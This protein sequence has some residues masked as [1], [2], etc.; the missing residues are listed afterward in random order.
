MRIDFVGAAAGT[1]AR[2]W[3]LD[4]PIR[5]DYLVYGSPQI[6]QPEIDEVVATLRSGWLGT[7]PRVAR[8]ERA[9]RDYVGA[10]HALAVHSGTAAAS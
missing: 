4:R 2:P 9:F 3:V 10:S 5:R 8:F 6:L 1:L 7:D